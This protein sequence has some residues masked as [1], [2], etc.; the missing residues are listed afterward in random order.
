MK[1]LTLRSLRIFEATA[2]CASI[3]R[4]AD[5]LEL[6]QPAVSM[7]IRQ[8]EAEVGM[9]LIDKRT[10]PLTLT[11]AGRELLV[12]ARAILSQVRIAEDALGS[13][14]GAL[15]GQLHLG[16]VGPAN[17]FAPMLM[18]AF[19]QLHPEVRLKLTL[20]KRDALLTSLAEHRLDIVIAGFPPALADVD[21]VPFARHPHCIVAYPHHRLASQ[22]SIAWEALGDEPF[23]FREPGSATRQ[24]L[25]HLL[26]SNAL[27]V[28]RATELHGNE[29]IKGA[30]MAGMGISFL[31]A[32]TFQLE[33]EVGRLV[34]LDVVDMP[35]TLDWCVLH[36]R[37]S[38]LTGV[39]EAFHAF[40]LAQGAGIAAC[41][42]RGAGRAH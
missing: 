27:R 2:A 24:F 19:R 41:R 35:K 37:D 17:Y 38:R 30:V 16:V 29:T 42:F 34:V 13:L 36:R 23:L 10:R 5:L 22:S 18:Q 39:N 3:S 33:A 21:A 6:T 32:H 31:S 7:Q 12:H 8:L 11:D 40:V 15:R 1:N 28:N 26:Q 4:A 25:D 20:D 9:T 14:Q